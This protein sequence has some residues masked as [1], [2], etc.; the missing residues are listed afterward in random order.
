M[1]V[2]IVIALTAAFTVVA[3]F[4]RESVPL[5]RVQ[6]VGYRLRRGWLVFLA[7]LGVATVGTSLF[8]LPYAEG[9]RPGET[10]KVTGGQFY[11]S[12]SRTS[13]TEGARVRF[14]VTSADVNHGFGLYDPRGKL[15]GSVQAMPGYRNR[16]DVTLST[17]GRYLVSCLEFCGVDHHRMIRYFKVVE[18]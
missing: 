9:T 14:D 5:E 15:L 1:F 2:V 12:M 13:F 8:F 11:W 3:L 7:L 6:E 17:P 4:S 18:R 10:V 16:L